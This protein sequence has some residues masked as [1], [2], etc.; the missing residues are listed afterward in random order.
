MSHIHM[1]CII[2]YQI[3]RLFFFSLQTFVSNIFFGYWFCLHLLISFLNIYQQ[4][5][6]V[7][8]SISVYVGRRT[9]FQK[10][11][12]SIPILC[13]QFIMMEIFKAIRQTFVSFGLIQCSTTTRCKEDAPIRRKINVK[14][15]TKLILCEPTQKSNV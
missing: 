8:C 1:K 10:N 14:T 9:I 2:F 7:Q 13:L 15:K 12:Q 4:V 6:S 3:F 5:L 11:H